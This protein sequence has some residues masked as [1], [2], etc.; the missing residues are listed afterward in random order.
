MLDRKVFDKY[1]GKKIVLNKSLLE[2]KDIS[3]FELETGSQVYY[4]IPPLDEKKDNAEHLTPLLEKLGIVNGV[5]SNSNNDKFM[6]I[7]RY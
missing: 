2:R 4:N 3:S 7:F 1:I 5:S 6:G